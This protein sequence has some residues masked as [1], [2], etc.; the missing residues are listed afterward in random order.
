MKEKSLLQKEEGRKETGREKK[1]SKTNKQ[2]HFFSKLEN[3]KG[4]FKETLPKQE[5]LA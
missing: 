1:Q 2:K 3:S 4:I 5:L